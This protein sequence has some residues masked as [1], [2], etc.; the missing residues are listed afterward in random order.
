MWC[1]TRLDAQGLRIQAATND[2]GSGLSQSVTL[3]NEGDAAISNRTVAL[4]LPAQLGLAITSVWGA[5]VRQDADGDLL[6]T[7]LDHN[8]S[9][10]AGG[11]AGFGFVASHA[12]G[13]PVAFAS[14]QFTFVSHPDLVM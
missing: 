9:V 8:A 7:A 4:D 3:T 10:A 11:T 5:S 14:S 2:W 13:E 12:G 6:F 1:P